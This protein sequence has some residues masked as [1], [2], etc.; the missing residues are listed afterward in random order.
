MKVNF[1]ANCLPA[2]IGSLPMDDHKEAIKLV[3]EYTP[4]IPLWVQLPSYKEEGMMV[5]FMEGLP[6]FTHKDNKVLIDTTAQGFETQIL[7]FYEEYIAVTEGVADLTDSRFALTQ[8]TAKGFFTFLEYV[9]TLSTPPVAVKGQITGP[10]TIGTGTPDQD[11]KAVFYNE[12]VRDAVVKQLAMGARWQVRELSRFNS[13]VIMFFDEPALTGFGSSA[14]I[15]ISAEEIA[16]CFD[17]VI[18]AVHAEGGL[19]GIHVCANA[20]W[21]LLLD[22]SVD[23]IS[24][25]AYAYFDRF[26]LYEDQVKK[27][28]EKGGILALGI[29]PTLNV[30]DVE[31]EDTESLVT[32]WEQRVEKFEKIGIDRS[33]ILSQSLITPSCGTGSLSLDNATKVLRMTKELSKRVRQDI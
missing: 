17:E 21:D 16:A 12:Q 13:P 5:Q 31:A 11:G 2:L 28:V 27:F 20:Q 32:K 10:V 14:F 33:K 8:K 22:S 9:E 29:V 3:V 18:D 7:S 23:I 26:V 19:A 4:E 30:K 25:D 15:S 6:G 24:F 1:N